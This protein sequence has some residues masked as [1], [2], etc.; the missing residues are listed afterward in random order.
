MI[1]LL[2]NTVLVMFFGIVPLFLISFI[3]F[4]GYRIYQD[5]VKNNPK[6]A[7]LSPKMVSTLG[8]TADALD[9]DSNEDPQKNIG[10]EQSS[11]QPKNEPKAL[12]KKVELPSSVM[13]NIPLVYQAYNL[14]CEATSLSMA[15]NYR[16]VN[17]TPQDLMSKI[18]YAEP[19]KKTF[20]DGKIIWGDPDKG[21]VGSE[22][23]YLFT[24]AAGMSGG[25]G[26]GVNNGPVAKVAESYLPGSIE[27]DNAKIEDLK[28]ALAQ[29][30]PVIF[31]HQRDD[32]RREVLTYTTPEGKEVKQFQNHVNLLIGYKTDT[33]GQTVYYFN[34]PIFGKIQHTEAELI[35][36]WGKYN[37]DIVVVN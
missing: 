20:K 36:I 6:A 26:W 3:T 22:K 11:K 7:S 10:P 21:F 24:K 2:K 4:A 13:L 17:V 23:G 19:I 8:Q 15:L 16:G 14:N 32:A 18:G 35:R 37:N 25:N 34:D 9:I 33:K 27:M 1:K 5:N 30:K 29:D 12:D 31:W 28:Q